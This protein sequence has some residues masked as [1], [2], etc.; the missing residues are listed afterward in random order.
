[1][2][3]N[4]SLKLFTFLLLIYYVQGLVEYKVTDQVFFDF[5][6]GDKDLGRVTFG[7]FGEIAPKTVQNFKTIAS[8]GINGKT[9]TGTKIIRAVQRFMIQGGD[10]VND[11]GSGSISIF[12]PTFKDENFTINHTCSGLLGMANSGPDTNGCQFY[13]TTMAAPWLDGKHVIFGKVLFGHG[14]VHK[15]EHMKTDVNDRLKQTVI[16][17][18]SGILTTNTEFYEPAENYELSLWGWIKAGW[19]PLSWSFLILGF[20]HYF[21]VKLDKLSP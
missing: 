11:D 6:K 12:G 18:K 13:I 10:I 2:F 16:I 19:I 15:I 8:E 17:S 14:V 4:G 7:L 20:F 21:I 5:K 3:P 1:M 9:Y